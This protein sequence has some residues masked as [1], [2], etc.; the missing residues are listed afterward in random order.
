MTRRLFCLPLPTALGDLWRQ[1]LVGNARR[2]VPLL[3]ACLLA[4]VGT[5][6]RPSPTVEPKPASDIVGAKIAHAARAQIGTAYA[7]GYVSMA[8]PNGDLAKDKGVCTDVIIRALRAVG[9]DLQQLIHE[10]MTSNFA[11]YPQLWGL[12]KPDANIDHRRVPNQMKYFERH[13]KTLALA[14]DAAS[15]EKWQPGD[16]VYWRL[17]NGLLH[18]GVVSDQK[19][20]GRP[21]VIHNLSIC[22][23]EDC[24]T[25]WKIIGHYRFR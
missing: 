9:R 16:F 25:Q 10:D 22:A 11:K 24:L 21:L 17:D 15:L 5:A 13:G 4:D 18:C 23:E 2:G 7:P 1:C 14:T 6:R 12:K 8:Y 3:R 19:A 20:N